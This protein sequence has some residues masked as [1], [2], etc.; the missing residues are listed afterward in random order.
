MNAPNRHRAVSF[1]QAQPNE[2]QRGTQNMVYA[3]ANSK[4]KDRTDMARVSL[5][6]S[7]CSALIAV[8]ARCTCSPAVRG[9]IART[10]A[11]GWAASAGTSSA[12]SGSG[13]G[14]LTA[15][16][17]SD[18]TP[19]RKSLLR[20]RDTIHSRRQLVKKSQTLCRGS[21]STQL[22]RASPQVTLAR[23]CTSEHSQP[24]S[25]AGQCFP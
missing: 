17:G 20:Q 18:G 9:T 19:R 5:P 2:K 4:V 10:L 23:S 3:S 13:H 7:S 16:S 14:T 6:L 1:L 21:A 12:T 15:T 11:G 8:C 25:T 24:A 22:L